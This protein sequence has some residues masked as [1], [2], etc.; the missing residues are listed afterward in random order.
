MIIKYILN[1]DNIKEELI[2]QGFNTQKISTIINIILNN[3][4]LEE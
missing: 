2:A 3:C 4:Y 1:I